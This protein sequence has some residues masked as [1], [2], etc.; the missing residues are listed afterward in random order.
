MYAIITTTGADHPGIVAALTTALAEHGANILDISQ[1][2]MGDFFT[3]ILRVS[4]DE[5][6]HPIADLQAAA[7]TVATAQHLVVRVQSEQLFTA[8]TQI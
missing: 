7:E 6:A 8:M 3:M 4:F 1:S 5:H 2:I